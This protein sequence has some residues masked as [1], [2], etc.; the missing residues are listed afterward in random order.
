MFLELII[1]PLWVINGIE[2][3]R[4]GVTCCKVLWPIF[5]G[6]P[7]W[8]GDPKNE[9]IRILHMDKNY[10]NLWIDQMYVIRHQI[11]EIS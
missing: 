9:N 10:Q 11:L 2:Q 3:Q 4:L 8:V 7:L 5:E 6:E 1:D